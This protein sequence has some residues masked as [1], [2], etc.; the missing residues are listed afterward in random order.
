MTESEIEVEQMKHATPDSELVEQQYEAELKALQSELDRVDR[1][2]EK[3]EYGNYLT[4]DTSKIQELK[5]KIEE[6]V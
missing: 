3:D 1:I 4:V 2:D 6:Y 5:T